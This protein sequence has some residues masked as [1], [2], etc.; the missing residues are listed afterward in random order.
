MLLPNTV[1]SAAGGLV[2]SGARRYSSDSS[3]QSTELVS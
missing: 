2:P 1:L 3:S